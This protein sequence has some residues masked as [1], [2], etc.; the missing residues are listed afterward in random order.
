[1]NPLA[2]Q[3]AELEEAFLAGAEANLNQS[4][5]RQL[6]GSSWT[7]T[8]RSE[9]GQVRELMTASRQHDREILR[10][11]PKNK[12][13]ILTGTQP[14]LLLWRRRTSV[15]IASVLSPLEHYLNGQG[16]PP[17]IGLAEV[18]SHVKKLTG[19]ADVP[20]LVGVCSPAGFTED[21]K[22]SGL[23]LANVTLVLIE[24]RQEGGWNVVPVNPEATEAD[25]KLFDPEAIM[26]KLRRVREEI[27]SRSADL[28]TGS[29]SACAISERLGLPEKLVATVFERAAGEEPEL[30]VSRQRHDVLLF[31]GAAESLEDSDMSIADRLRHLFSGEGDETKKINA[32]SERR[33]KLVQRRDCIYADLTQLEKREAD[34]LKQGREAASATTKRRAA[35]QI[36]QLRNDMQRLTATANML[37][38]QVGVISTHI[39][40]LTLIQQGEAAEL[41]TAEEIT[42]DAARA[43]EMIE[44]LGADTEL[45]S[46][47]STGVSETLMSDEELD[48]LKE[49]EVTPAGREEAKPAPERS[50]ADRGRTPATEKKDSEPR[51]PE[52]G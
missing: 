44:Q 12:T 45:A 14:R 52:A 42:A 48:I 11:M 13:R 51:E 10:S 23:E 16:D 32:L 30:K 34:L 50:P 43:E 39:H 40:N 8:T 28:V 31:R 4:R 18:V 21:A 19:E 38:Q 1:M 2:K 41:P 24:P 37:G 3:A 20:H 25:G 6:R 46:S 7:W 47:L 17:P 49:L 5:G 26:Q 33:A 15:A 36:K 22:T 27:E 29:L 35:S 9:E